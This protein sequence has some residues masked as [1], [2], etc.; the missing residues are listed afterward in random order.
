MNLAARLLRN[1]KLSLGAWRLASVYMLE[2]NS[3]PVPGARRV[4]KA[5]SESS[6][7]FHVAT[8]PESTPHKGRAASKR[9]GLRWMRPAVMIPP[10]EC[11]HA[12]GSFW[13]PDHFL[14]QVEN[15]DLVRQCFMNGPSGRGVGRAGQC[16]TARKHE[17]TSDGITDI[18][19]RIRTTRHYIAMTVEKIGRAS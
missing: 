17:K 8:P 18:L 3:G 9:S 19:R 15:G 16:K 1:Y 6:A 4:L 12:M 11:P 13:M 5:N 10:S 2:T 7:V 14:K